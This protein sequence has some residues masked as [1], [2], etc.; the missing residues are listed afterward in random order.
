MSARIFKN[1]E[2]FD[3]E[4]TYDLIPLK[5]CICPKTSKSMNS[6]VAILPSFTLLDNKNSFNLPETYDL[7]QPGY[8]SATPKIV[9]TADKNTIKPIDKS[10]LINKTVDYIVPKL[11]TL[12]NDKP[13]EGVTSNDFAIKITEIVLNELNSNIPP[14]HPFYSKIKK[15]DS[16]IDTY[17]KIR[18]PNKIHDT[19]SEHVNVCLSK[20]SETTDQDT[21]CVE[22][23]DKIIQEITKESMPEGIK[24]NLKQLISNAIKSGLNIKSEGKISR[25]K[26]INNIITKTKAII[27]DELLK[28]KKTPVPNATL[29]QKANTIATKVATAISKQIDTAPVINKDT[30]KAVIKVV[31]ELVKPIISSATPSVLVGVSQ[32]KAPGAPA[33][34]PAAKTVVTQLVQTDPKKNPVVPTISSTNSLLKDNK[35]V[36]P[37]NQIAPI[38]APST[39]SISPTKDIKSV[40]KITPTQIEVLKEKIAEKFNQDISL[41]VGEQFNDFTVND[42]YEFLDAKVPVDPILTK[43]ATN[44]INSQTSQVVSSTLPSGSLAKAVVD[45]NKPL[46]KTKTTPVTKVL[47]KKKGLVKLANN[48]NKLTV[49]VK[50]DTPINAND[51]KILAETLAPIITQDIIAKTLETAETKIVVNDKTSDISVTV[52]IPELTDKK[53]TNDIT[54]NIKNIVGNTVDKIKNKKGFTLTGAIVLIA[55]V[56]GINYK[57]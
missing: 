2:Y 50:I 29:T 20:A 46:S 18:H 49:G 23:A 6:D 15:Y 17:W 28:A 44:T 32:N 26:I 35:S 40:T 38:P 52:I 30:L 21:F 1:R 53:L 8:N 55:L 4:N 24:S 3:I 33:V 25:K 48:S 31:P 13:K 47:I 9:I 19:V 39:V 11:V 42:I 22:I 34:T 56:L 5:P 37:S 36:G 41:V 57:F 16:E 27:K 45:I 7:K 10:L 51:K 43:T 54:N 12:I 14:N